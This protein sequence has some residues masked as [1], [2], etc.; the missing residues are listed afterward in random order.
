MQFAVEP[1]VGQHLPAVGLQGAAIVVQTHSSDPADQSVGDPGG[2]FPLDGSVLALMTPAA[3][4]VVALPQ[5]RQQHRNVGWIVL[6]VSIK[7]H[8]HLP[9]GHIEP[10]GHGGGLAVVLAQQHRHQFRHLSAQSLQHGRCAVTG[11]IVHQHQFET[12]PARSQGI[13]Q[14]LH[15]MRQAFLLVVQR[16][17]HRKIHGGGHRCRCVH[18]GKLNR[19]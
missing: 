4:Q 6:E 9:L 10:G 12:F 8:D 3:H 5:R 2:D 11:A 14:L 16:H 18:G 13:Q 15:Q 19:A 1:H 17:H 7:A